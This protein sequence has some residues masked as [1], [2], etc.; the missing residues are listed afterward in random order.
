MQTTMTHVM[1]CTASATG[2]KAG[3]HTEPLHVKM[4]WMS[5]THVMATDV[6]MKRSMM[7]VT[8]TSG[9]QGLTLVHFPAQCKHLLWARG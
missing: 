4:V 2:L 6:K 5:A 8:G 7:V 3:P 9:S 1:Y